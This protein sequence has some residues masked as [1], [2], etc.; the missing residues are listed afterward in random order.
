MASTDC[1]TSD[2]LSAP[3][4]YNASQSLD[5]GFNMTFQYQA[6]TASGEVYWEQALLG[7]FGIGYQALRESLSSVL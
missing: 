4:L 6:G 3:A 1:T 7:G 2:C 5:S